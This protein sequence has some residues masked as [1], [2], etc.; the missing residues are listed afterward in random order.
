MQRHTHARCAP[1]P[2][3][4]GQWSAGDISRLL[5]LWSWCGVQ[6]AAAV[7]LG[8]S[9]VLLSRNLPWTLC[10]ACL[11]GL[12]AQ[13]SVLCPGLNLPR[14][15]FHSRP[16]GSEDPLGNWAWPPPTATPSACLGG[17]HR[18]IVC[19]P[20]G[21]SWRAPGPQGRVLRCCLLQQ[22]PV[23]PPPPPM[24]LRPLQGFV[25]VPLRL[26]AAGLWDVKAGA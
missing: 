23:C 17:A 21:Q 26:C 18:E 8:F 6:T 14:S 5:R 9:K 7:F 2:R 12:G 15:G 13:T 19:A 25:A 1:P 3:P 4:S 10:S 22:D 16:V 24:P 11:R 20:C